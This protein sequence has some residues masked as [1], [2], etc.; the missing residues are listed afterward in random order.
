VRERERERERWYVVVY[1]FANV[2]GKGKGKQNKKEIKSSFLASVSTTV[3]CKAWI[4]H[5]PCSLQLFYKSSLCEETMFLFF[6]CSFIFKD[7]CFS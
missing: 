7:L 2:L 6:C 4:E 5:F 3:K 1:V